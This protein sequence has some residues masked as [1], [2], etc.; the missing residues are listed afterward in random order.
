MPIESESNNCTSGA[1]LCLKMHATLLPG[2]TKAT[3]IALAQHS[4]FNLASHSSPSRILDHTLHMPNCC[5]RFTPVDDTSLPTREVQRV[6]NAGAKSMDFLHEG[7]VLADAL[8]QYGEERAGLER[9]VAMNNV[10]RILKTKT[11]DDGS[12]RVAR[13]P[14]N[15]GAY[16]FDQ[17]YVIHDEQ[18]SSSER[19]SLHLAAIL[20]HPPTRRSLR[21]STTAPGMQLYTANYLDGTIPSPALCKGGW[22]YHQWQG[23]CLETQTYPDSIFPCDDGISD[24]DEF[25]KG[26]CFVLRPGGKEY[27]HD[28]EF[29]FCSMH[30]T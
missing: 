4:Y 18:S 13:T 8:V 15:G 10:H 23:I 3:P 27:F 21:V 9:S 29:E 1:K 28:V 25:A 20:V 30:L 14:K 26:R 5:A 2:E 7:K 11:T 24:D 6:D 22:R 12:G 19:D 17:N 16:G